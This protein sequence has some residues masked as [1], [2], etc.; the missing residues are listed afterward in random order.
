MPDDRENHPDDEQKPEM[1]PK[2]YKV[3]RG[4][5]PKDRQWKPGQSGN[6][7]GK[8]KPKPSYGDMC[9]RILLERI[10]GQENGSPVSLTRAKA[11][12]KGLV[13]RGA[14]LGDPVDEDVLLTFEKPWDSAPT[15]YWEFRLVDS[16]DDIPP[17]PKTRRRA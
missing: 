17:E 5:P 12:V 11:W 16:E 1:D 4:K 8:R 14:L 13:H 9:N 15:K 10:P 7:S 3:G 6:R 2:P